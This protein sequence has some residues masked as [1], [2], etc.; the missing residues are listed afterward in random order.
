MKKMRNFGLILIILVLILSACAPQAAAPEQEEPAAE[1]EMAA[2][3]E[4]AVVEEEEAPMELQTLI[5]AANIDDLITLDPAWAGETTNQFIHANT[6]ETLVEF[7]PSDFGTPLPKLAESW[8]AA[9]GAQEF[10][11]HLRPDA[12]FSSGNPVTA[13][14]VAFSW[15]RGK[16]MQNWFFD[17]IESVEVIDDL[18][19]KVNLAYP[20]ADFMAIISTPGLGITDSVTI[21]AQGGTDAEDAFE[22]DT[23]KEWLDN[24]SAGSAPYVMTSWAQKSEVVLE[25]NENYYGDKPY[26]DRVIIKHVEDP[27]TMLQMLQKG[28][29]D[30]L[31][32]LDIDLVDLAQADDN[33]SVVVSQTLD[34]NYLAMTS[35][36]A[37]EVGPETAAVMC[38]KEVRQAIVASIDYEGLI[39]AVLMGYGTRAPSIIPI[40]MPGVD[41]AKVEGRDVEKAKT[42]LADAGFAEGVTLDLF[43]NVSPVRETIAAKIQSDL[44]EAGMTVNLNPLEATVYLDQMRAQKLPFAFG[45]WTPD[46]LD[47]T[48]WTDYYSSIEN[49]VAYR[50]WFDNARAGE[51]KSL[52]KGEVDPA[53]RIEYIEELQGIW[54]DESPFTMLYQNQTIAAMDS[55]L[56]GY[57]YHP[58]LRMKIYELRK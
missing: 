53:V 33:L 29:V 49:G 58:S 1:E 16:N 23:A 22:S 6:Y 4:E 55:T 35:N 18:T 42:L 39:N 50:M 8:E 10:T 43:Y 30:I 57:A 51:L 40:G 9:E 11:F 52:I 32:S 38:I 24:Q 3:E 13:K 27:T 45:G 44:A 41:P 20:S 5:I 28:D 46:Y 37:T 36:C 14:D 19:V 15:M 56:M 12:V 26:Y 25:Y 21:M 54:M 48:L 31:P 34:M 7:D 17:P 47:V 2:E